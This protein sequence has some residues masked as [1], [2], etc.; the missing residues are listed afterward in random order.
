MLRKTQGDH[1]GPLSWSSKKDQDEKYEKNSIS[2]RWIKIKS[3]KSI[4]GSDQD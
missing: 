4:S 1:T 2:G 3:T